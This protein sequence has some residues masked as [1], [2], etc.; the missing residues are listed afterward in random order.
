MKPFALG[1]LAAVT[2]M[3]LAA[4]A[5]VLGGALDVAAD[6]PHHRLLLRALELARERAIG[7]AASA[8]AVPADIDR[9]SRIAAGAGNYAAMCVEC[10]LSPGSGD[11]EIR[12]GLYPRP[13]DLSAKTDSAP[14][15]APF[16]SAA[17]RQFWIVK[18]GIK[19]SGMAAWG[20]AGLS[21]DDIWNLVAFLRVLPTMNADAY[22]NA[23]QASAGHSHGGEAIHAQHHD[24]DPSAGAKP[25]VARKP[26]HH[27][28]PGTP[29][30]VDR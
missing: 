5:L 8:I 23:V 10:H 3:L 25:A 16:A 13:P 20:I 30:H 18:H 12:R 7:R 4:T 21:D 2:A 14:P 17:A 27:H 28:A 22:L 26:V 29:A 11:S 6:S 9:A 19:A 15:Q 1:V 24:A